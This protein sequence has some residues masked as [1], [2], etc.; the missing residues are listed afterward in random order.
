LFRGLHFIHDLKPPFSHAR[1][2]DPRTLSGREQ[3][4]ENI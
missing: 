2:A 3:L 1:L 4:Y